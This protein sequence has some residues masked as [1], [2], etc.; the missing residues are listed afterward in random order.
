M[1][2]MLGENLGLTHLRYHRP[3]EKGEKRETWS[4]EKLTIQGR[5]QCSSRSFLKKKINSFSFNLWLLIPLYVYI[6]YTDFF[7]RLKLES[8]I[9]ILLSLWYG[10]NLFF[11]SWKLL[12]VSLFLFH[13]IKFNVEFLI[14]QQLPSQLSPSITSAACGDC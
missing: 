14:K 12:W 4:T 8:K 5:S 11:F 7:K 10:P 3:R 6:Y 2:S 9:L 1:N 13:L